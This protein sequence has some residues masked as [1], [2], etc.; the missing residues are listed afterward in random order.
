MPGH[1]YVQDDETIKGAYLRGACGLWCLHHSP[2]W[3][4]MTQ[5][6]LFSIEH[7]KH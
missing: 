3:D 1:N 4:L 2:R 5:V 6:A 7:I